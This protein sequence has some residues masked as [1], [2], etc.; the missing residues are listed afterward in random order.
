MGILARLISA[1][2]NLD[3]YTKEVELI[4]DL[5]EWKS[6]IKNY[7]INDSIIL[8]DIIIKFRNLVYGKWEIDINKHPTAPSL[9]FAIFRQRYLEKGVIPIIKG[10]V[11]EFIKESYTGG[12]TEMYKP[13]PPK[14][15]KIH[16]YDVN[17]LYPSRMKTW[18]MP[19]GPIRQ[20]EGDITI[21]D[22]DKYYWIGDA[23]VNTKRNMYQPYLQIH[24]DTNKGFRTEA[25]NGNFRM[26]I[27]S[28]E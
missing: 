15:T 3:T 28:P 23:E 13:A 27:N 12:S 4:K 24:C 5:N 10:K 16:C 21:L 20:F 9:G 2:H 26:K 1:A 8:Y 6:K 17:G 19:T 14:G 25:M 11:Y 18:G 22:Q 7:C